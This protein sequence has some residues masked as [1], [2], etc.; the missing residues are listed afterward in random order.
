MS[1]VNIIVDEASEIIVCHFF[2]RPLKCFFGLDFSTHC[3]NPINGFTR[4]PLNHDK[5]C[6]GSSG[7]EAAL[8]G[9]GGSGLGF[10]TDIGGS[11]RIP[12]ALCGIVGFKPT[13]GRFRYQYL[14][15]IIFEYKTSA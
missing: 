5:T 7:G 4:N 13:T 8:I 14:I 11:V 1:F 10:G 15:Q 2:C 9:G 12:A 3:S 6:H